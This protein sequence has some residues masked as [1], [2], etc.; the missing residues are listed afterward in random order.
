MVE[1]RK[2]GERRERGEE[3]KCSNE[4]KGKKGGKEGRRIGKRMDEEEVM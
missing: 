1:Q 4:W 3:K 2:P